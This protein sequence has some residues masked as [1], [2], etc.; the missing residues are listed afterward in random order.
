M[1]TS[2]VPLNSGVLVSGDESFGTFPAYDDVG[3]TDDV[4]RGSL[5]EGL[6]F[7]EFRELGIDGALDNKHVPIR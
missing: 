4:Q 2:I 6:A 5:Q 3:A 7:I 1:L